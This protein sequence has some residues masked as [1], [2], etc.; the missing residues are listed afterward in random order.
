MGKEIET[1]V[2][3]KI[4]SQKDGFNVVIKAKATGGEAVNV[5]NTFIEELKTRGFTTLKNVPLPVEAKEA[6]KENEQPPPV[7]PTHHKELLKRNG[8]FGD[9]WACPTKDEQGNWCQWRPEK[10]KK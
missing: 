4:K 6:I 8:K 2:K 1:P 9:F 3:I 7:C 10:K 5:A